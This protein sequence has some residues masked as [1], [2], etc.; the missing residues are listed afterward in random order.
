[1]AV[2]IGVPIL[3][4]YVY[5]V[6]PVSLCR[7][8]GCGVSASSSGVRLDFDEPDYLN[9]NMM[10]NKLSNGSQ[11]TAVDVDTVSHKENNPSIGEVS[12]SLGSGTHLEHLGRELDRESASTVA[13]AGSIL[14][15]K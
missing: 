13:L 2:A 9:Q 14:A 11:S 1:M 10:A 3:L 15:H 4:F 8:S 12:L 6:V 7:S 5:G